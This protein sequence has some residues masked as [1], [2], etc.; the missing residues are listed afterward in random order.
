MHVKHGSLGGI[1]P[2]LTLH[3]LNSFEYRYCRTP[4]IVRLA[5]PMNV[6][7]LLD[8]ERIKLNHLLQ[9]SEL[10]LTTYIVVTILEREH[11]RFKWIS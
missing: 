7:D 9:E 5:H 11:P 4:D 3:G 2:D 8:S 1:S 10:R 6:R